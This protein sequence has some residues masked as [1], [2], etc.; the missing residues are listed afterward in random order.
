MLFYITK[1][2][3]T[4]WMTPI[5]Q[6]SGSLAG[7]SCI[8]NVHIPLELIHASVPFVL[9]VPVPKSITSQAITLLYHSPY[10]YLVC[11]N[12]ANGLVVSAYFLHYVNSHHVSPEQVTSEVFYSEPL[13]PFD[14][15][16]ADVMKEDSVKC[17]C[18]SISHPGKF[19]YFVAEALNAPAGNIMP[20]DIQE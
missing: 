13:P 11:P 6:G 10:Q 8:E 12:T 16:F 9:I 3:V 2:D 20:K 5:L 18:M 7:F 15:A 4:E 19:P 1:R 17:L 14:V